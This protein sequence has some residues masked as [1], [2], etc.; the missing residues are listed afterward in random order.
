MLEIICKNNNSKILVPFGST[1]NEVGMFAGVKTEFP[2]L[3]AYVNNKVQ[4]ISYKV[5]MPKTVEFIDITNP[6]G[7]RMY[8]LSLMFLLYKAV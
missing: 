4:N 8:A 2:I 3:G 7:R 6:N 5:F 1:V